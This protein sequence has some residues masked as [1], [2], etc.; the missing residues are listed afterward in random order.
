MDTLVM[1]GTLSAILYSI[2]ATAQIING[3]ASYV[4][5]L[6]YDTAAMIITLIMLGKTLETVSK[7]KTSQA[8]K[9]LMKLAPDNAIVI[10][11]G[12]EVSVPTKELTAGDILLIKPGERIPVDGVV[13]EGQSSIMNRCSLG[14]VFQLIKQ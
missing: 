3:D 8:M 11:D 12:R 13:I 2:Y 5:H 10:I 9:K 4:H 6:Y 14:R 1:T 7:A